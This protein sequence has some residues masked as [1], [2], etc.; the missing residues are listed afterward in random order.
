MGPVFA[1]LGGRREERDPLLLG[2]RRSQNVPGEF[3]N[4]AGFVDPDPIE[5]GAGASVRI[6]ERSEVDL[7]F[8][9]QGQRQPILGPLG[10]GMVEPLAR[11]LR[12][13]RRQHVV[14]EFRVRRRAAPPDRVRDRAFLDRGERTH[15]RL[16]TTASRTQVE[17]AVRAD[18]AYLTARAVHAA[19]E[20]RPRKPFALVVGTGTGARTETTRQEERHLVRVVLQRDDRLGVGEPRTRH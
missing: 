1:P 7:R 17:A 6:V 3:L 11:Q 15:A 13:E 14:F 18:A 16:A 9:R 4:L 12:E 5:A 19:I 20:H 10:G 8:V 2:E